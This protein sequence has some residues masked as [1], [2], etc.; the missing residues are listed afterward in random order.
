MAEPTGL[1]VVVTHKGV[2]RWR[3]HAVGRA[4]H[5]SCPDSGEN[6][7]Y[8][9]GHAV[10]QLQRYAEVLKQG[11][12]RPAPRATDDQRGDHSRWDLRQCRARSLHDRNRSSPDSRGRLPRR[13]ANRSSIGWHNTSPVADRLRHDPP[14]LVSRGLSEQ[15]QHRT[16]AA[17]AAGHPRTRRRRAAN[18]RAVR[19]ECAVLRRRRTCRPSSSARA[20]SS[21]RTRRHEWVSIDQLHTAVEVYS[22]VGRGETIH[23]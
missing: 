3:C 22:A 5:S 19:H 7:I 8:H 16:R 4:A 9:M 23:G 10:L 13:P 1:H 21:R 14:F 11:A 2:V 17:T 18:W 12:L 15:R 20:P 6:A